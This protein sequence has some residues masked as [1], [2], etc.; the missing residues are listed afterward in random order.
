IP[1]CSTKCHFCDFTVY[2][3]QGEDVQSAYVERLCTEIAR[4][5]E[6]RVF[7][8]YT[9]D[10]IYFGGGTPGLLS[11]DQL[12]SILKACRDHYRVSQE[13]EIGVEFDPDA[14]N[15]DKLGALHEG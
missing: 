15:E 1:F 14:A 9:I 10:A 3:G 12:L 5:A 4:Q 6:N 8:E 2:V 13:A 7:P 11:S